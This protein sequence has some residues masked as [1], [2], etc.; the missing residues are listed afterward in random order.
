M[1]LKVAA[2]LVSPRQPATPI[3]VRGAGEGGQFGGRKGC[4]W[5]ADSRLNAMESPAEPAPPRFTSR[6]LTAGGPPAASRTSGTTVSTAPRFEPAQVLRAGHG[7]P[8]GARRV[9]DPVLDGRLVR[10]SGGGLACDSAEDPVFNYASKAALDLWEVDWET[11]TSTRRASARAI[12]WR[13]ARR[14]SCLK[15]S[16]RTDA[17]RRLRGGRIVLRQAGKVRDAHV[18][19]VYDEGGSAWAGG[20][21]SEE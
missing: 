2:A 16:R 19:N 14:R 15:R 13:S 10:R 3:T 21:V 7:D 12:S 9:T 20:A 1:L 4:C 6:R 17:R 5:K 11:F 18:W 8:A